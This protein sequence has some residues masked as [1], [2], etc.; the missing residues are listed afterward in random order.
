MKS[1][2][3]IVWL[4]PGFASSE[5]DDYTTPTLQNLALQIKK[6]RPEIRISIIAIHFP[7]QKGKYEWNG[8]DVYTIGGSNCRYP[9]RFLVWRNVIKLISNINLDH[10]VDL[11]HSSA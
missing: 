3:H 4:T 1:S 7:Y 8:I 9:K 10:P 11:I 6:D 2:K 5:E